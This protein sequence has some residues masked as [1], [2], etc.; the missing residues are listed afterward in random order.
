MGHGITLPALLYRSKD[1][2]HWIKAK[3]PLHSSKD[4]GM[5]ECPDFFP[6]LKNGFGSGVDTS[7]LGEHVK[8]VL[9]VS[10]DDKKYEYYTVGNYNLSSDRY[11]PD[12]TSADNATGLRYDYG[13]FYAS[14]TLFDPS[15]NRRVLWG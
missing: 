1:F 13:K 2:V 5:R 9:N 10:L 4:T 12:G 8:H 14:K 6:V 3:H 15:K 7:V 11:V